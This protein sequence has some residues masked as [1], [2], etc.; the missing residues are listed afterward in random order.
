[1]LFVIGLLVFA[2]VSLAL[3]AVSSRRASALETRMDTLRQVTRTENAPL[4]DEAAPFGDRVFRPALR[5]VGRLAMSLLPTSILKNVE[6]QLIMAGSP[7]NVVT[8]A[9]IWLGVVVGGAFFGLLMGLSMGSFGIQTFSMLVFGAVVGYM[10]PRMWLKSRVGKR[11]KQVLRALPDA[12]DMITTCV[13][14]GLGLDAALARVAERTEGP[15]GKELSETLREIAMGRLRRDALTEMGDRT[16]VEDLIMFVGAI[17]QAEQ[18][19]VGITQVLRVQSE[20]M[21]VRRRQRAERAAHEAPVK[22][23]IPLVFFVFPAFLVVIL[24]PAI[25]ELTREL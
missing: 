23:M 3:V 14:A 9:S 22:M 15:L 7:T 12:L 1:M 2:A 20:Q 25:I 24:G 8:F 17:T 4:A 21:R 19:G 18:L 10:L 11:Q 13:E 6:Q 16:G 5:G